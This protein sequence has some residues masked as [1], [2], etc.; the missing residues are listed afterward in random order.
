MKDVFSMSTY[1]SAVLLFIAMN[2]FAQTPDVPKTMD[3]K[4]DASVKPDTEKW[5]GFRGVN[6]GTDIKTLNGF[7]SPNA[8]LQELG[9]YLRKDESLKLGGASLKEVLWRFYKG[10]LYH[11]V[12]EGRD[13]TFPALKE[14]T[15]T[16]YGKA[17]KNISTKYKEAYAW[18]GLN[19]KGEPVTLE[20][21]LDKETGRVSCYFTYIPLEEQESKEIEARN[22]TN[23]NKDREAKTAVKA[24]S[25][26]EDW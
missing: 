12:I 25:Q 6:W 9:H 5:D 8:A 17:C 26:K 24:R 3:T 15:E 18:K 2:V 7:T 23:T 13:G 14:A 22:A 1:C 10:Q 21:S 20:V 4:K 19:S 11:V 16:R